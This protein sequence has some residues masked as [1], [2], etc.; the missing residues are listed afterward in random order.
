MSEIALRRL[1]AQRLLGPP[2]DSAVEAVRWLTAVQSQDLSGAKWGLAQRTTEA[3]E[4]QLDRLLDEGAILRTHVMRPTW[5]FVLPE[6][7]RW[8]LELTSPRLLAGLAGR[9]RRLELDQKTIARSAALFA[10][11]LSGGRTM[12][13]TELGEVLLAAGV[14]PEGQ[15]LPHLLMSAEAQGILISGPRRGNQITYALLEERAPAA[16]R[17]EREEALAR[18]TIRYFRSHGPAQIQDFAWWSGLTVAD[19]RRGLALVGAALEHH[20]VD[21]TDYWFDPS[22]APDRRAPLTAHLLPNFDEFTVAYR[23]R[24][25]VLDPDLPFDP[26]LFANYREAAP[27]SGVLSNVLTIGGTVRGSW[28]RTL[29][30]K[31]VKVEVRLLGPLAPALEAAVERAAEQ[32]GRFLHRRADLTF[33]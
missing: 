8:L 11:R 18:L 2:F 16:R 31:A 1:Y 21:G 6:D 32:F 3:T 4:S 28:R 13:R 30:L 29:T 25:A 27:L 24:R 26:T 23:D 9:Y 12:T 20:A 33:V 7:I 14:S 19:I 17:L 5:H 22:S 15:R 10:E